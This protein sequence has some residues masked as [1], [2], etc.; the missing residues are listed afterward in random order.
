MLL[1]PFCHLDIKIN[2]TKKKWVITHTMII[3]YIVKIVVVNVY[4]ISFP[5]LRKHAYPV[6]LRLSRHTP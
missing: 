6:L 1:R 4:M 3:V 5:L 2:I